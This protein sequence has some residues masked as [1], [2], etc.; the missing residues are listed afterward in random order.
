MS[1]PSE[2][3]IVELEE[4][5]RQAMLRS[6]VAELDALIS[7]T[8]LFTSHLGQVVSKQQDLDMHRSGVLKLTE[9]IPSDQHI[10]HHDG[11]SIVSVQMHLLGSYGDAVVD[12]QIRYTRVWS[13]SSVGSLHIVAGHASVV[14]I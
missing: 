14:S 10:Q 13:A 2:S 7:P 11:F 5:L 8:L 1:K 9:L 12:E 6:N 4:R 3:Q